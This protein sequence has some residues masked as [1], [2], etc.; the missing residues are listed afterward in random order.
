[1]VA[2]DPDDTD[3][4]VRTLEAPADNRTEM[5]W[6]I[7]PDSLYR[8]LTWIQNVTG[9]LPLYITENGAAF[10]DEPVDGRVQDRRR[11]DYI[12]DHLE[13]AKRFID[14]G[15]PLKGYFLWSFMDNFEWAMGYSKRFGMVYV[16]YETQKRVVK[17]SGRWFSEQIA[18]HSSQV[19]A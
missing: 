18:A 7:H 5:G 9:E 17:D 1:V 6:E 12:A 2:A 16:D 13:A 19:R 8:I 3:F 4:G 11:L 10:A 14:E 15:G